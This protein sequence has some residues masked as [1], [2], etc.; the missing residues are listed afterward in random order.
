MIYPPPQA[1]WGMAQPPAPAQ[2]A[3][4]P[5]RPLASVPRGLF[6][7]RYAMV[8]AVLASLVT[9]AGIALAAVAPLFVNHAADVVPAQWTLVYDGGLIDNG[10]FERPDGC[11]FPSS[12]LH[13]DGNAA[14]PGCK[15]T[16]S[17]SDDLTSQGFYLETTVAPPADLA[18]EEEPVVVVGTG[19]SALLFRFDQTGTYIV[20]TDPCEQGAGILGLGLTAGWHTNG[21]T[22]NTIAVR[23]DAGV[24]QVTLYVNSQEVLTVGYRVDAGAQLVLAADAGGEALYTHFTLYSASATG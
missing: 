20:C 6:P 8:I 3:P 22:S 4:Q 21:F 10:T 7:G 5:L 12:G 1:S 13:V 9:L 24:G 18:G 14:T 17:V 16:R 23:Y 2:P 11:T 19:R 15:L